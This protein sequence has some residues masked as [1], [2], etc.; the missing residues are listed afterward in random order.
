M[1]I[2]SL[3]CSE[4]WH[5]AKGI[6]RRVSK[7]KVSKPSPPVHT[8]ASS[9]ASPEYTQRV[10][11][12]GTFPDQGHKEEIRDDAKLSSPMKGCQVINKVGQVPLRY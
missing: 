10:V 8:A 4:S 1:N 2:F 5:P 9:A 6:R 3:G 7:K 11:F 12:Y